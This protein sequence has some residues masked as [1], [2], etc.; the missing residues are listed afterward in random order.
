M[1]GNLV[2]EEFAGTTVMLGEIPVARALPVRGRRMVGPWCFL[3][4]FGPLTFA[5]GKPMDVAPHPH[6]GLQTVTWLLDGE[7]VHDDSLGCEAVARP[8][9]VNVMTAG[10][11][12]AHTEQTPERNSGRLEGVQLWVALREAVRNGASSFAAVEA[13]PVVEQSGGLARVF[14]GAYGGGAS[15]APHFSPIVG[16]DFEVH[17]GAGLEAGLEP[18]FEHAVVLLR[19]DAA[20]EGRELVPNRLYFLPAGRASVALRSR[21]GARV[22]LIGGAP[23]GEKILMWWNFVARRP[24]E[25]V[26]ARADWEARARFGE[27][28][29]YRGERLGAPELGWLAERR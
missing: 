11:G 13:V 22:M 7:I 16:V 29:A 1:D 23:F 4:R 21:G 9:G 10:R 3:D 18:E 20:F 19:G 5:A 12:I 26:A 15:A 24:E 27:V 6:I 8:G 28:M 17:A 25:I 2:V 14:A